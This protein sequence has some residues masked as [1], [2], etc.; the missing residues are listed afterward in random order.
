[1]LQLVKN[2]SAFGVSLF[3]KLV[4]VLRRRPKLGV[5]PVFDK[6]SLELLTWC[7]CTSLL[8]SGTGLRTVSPL[9]LSVTSELF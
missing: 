7:S 4:S 6:G 3:L 1:M 8:A 5:S 9:I 2:Y